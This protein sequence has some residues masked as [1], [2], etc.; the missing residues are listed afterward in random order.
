MNRIATN[1]KRLSVFTLI[2]GVAVTISGCNDFLSVNDDPNTATR[3]QIAQVPGNLLPQA[4]TSLATNKTAEHLVVRSWGQSWSGAGFGLFVDGDDYVVGGLQRNNTYVNVY[5]SVAGNLSEIVEITESAKSNP[6]EVP[7]NP[8][9]VQA[10]AEII[11]QYSFLY[12]TEFFGA[13]P[14]EEANQPNT[15]PEPNPDSQEEILKSIIVR[16]D[17]MVNQ[18]NVNEDGLTNKDFFY[19]GDMGAWRNLANSIKLKAYFLLLS[20]NNSQTGNGLN[21]VVDPSVSMQ[22]EIEG[23]VD[24]GN[25][26]SSND[27]NFA[28]E[29]QDQATQRNPFYAVGNQFAGGENI[30]YACSEAM[31]DEMLDLNDPRISLYCQEDQVS[32]PPAYTGLPQGQAGTGGPGLSQGQIQESMVSDVFHRP[33]A[34][35]EFVT[36]AEVQLMEAE[37]HLRNGQR[38]AAYS[39]FTRGIETS[40]AEVN[41]YPNK[42]AAISSS[43]IQN[44]INSLPNQSNLTLEDIQLQQWIDYFERAPEVWTHWR[45]TKVP[46]LDAPSTATTS[47]RKIIRRINLPTAELSSNGNVSSRQKETDMWFEG[48]GSN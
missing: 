15:F 11:R 24:N 47:G 48:T 13:V 36:A 12:L 19:S 6:S 42:P 4:A 46:D 33:T 23:I 5:A 7:Y 14:Y 43:E 35:E 10:Q 25:L 17:E 40:I 32:G 30:H 16:L 8:S 2:L 1:M 38:G 26:L 41:T 34:P 3:E 31:V 27:R 22:A 29:Y 18:I 20:G 45:R 21:G 39:K 28:F 37:W 9:N 44:Y